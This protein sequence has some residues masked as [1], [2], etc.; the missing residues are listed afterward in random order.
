MLGELDRSQPRVGEQLICALRD[1]IEHGR[2]PQ[3][4]RLP[5]TRDL[6][7]DLGVSRGL[8]VGAY[9]RL[10]A[11]GR[12]AARRG[13]GTVVTAQ[14]EVNA[15]EPGPERPAGH[16]TGIPTRPS[17]EPAVVALRPGVPDLGTF[18]R[19]AWRKAYERALALA[20][21]ADLDYGDPAG[22]FRLRAEL[23]AYLTRIRAARVDVDRLMITSGETQAFALL[24]ETLRVAGVARIGVEDPGS[25][26]VAT[27]LAWHGLEPVAVAVDE[28]GID[29]AA[30]DRAGLTTVVVTPA[31]Q[32]PTGV[33]LMP[34]RRVALLDWARRTGSLIIENDYDAELRYD[35]EPVGCLQG[36][37]PE[38]VM[39]VGSVSTTLAP[40]LRLGWLASPRAW[41]ADLH[42][43]RSLADG[44]GPVLEQL[45]FA[46]LLAG[47]AYDRHLR[48]MRRVLRERR[49]TLVTAL[50]RHLPSARV[51]GAAAGLHLTIE[52]PDGTDDVALATRAQAAGIG[53]LAL[54][55]CLL[56]AGGAAAPADFADPAT[57]NRRTGLVLG[58]AAQSSHELA[59]AVRGLAHLIPG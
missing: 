3:G 10:V 4:T 18:P 41:R 58:Y 32:Y 6:A 21:D 42:R 36:L 24:A 11:E 26:A 23:A 14:S 8:V 46:E 5:S 28:R 9:E 16:G 33:V 47:A 31:H 7:V 39:L 44:G 35:R 12:L 2:L 25:R 20:A 15:A 54:S 50:R 13:R 22:A 19:T 34:D 40:A 30:L 1:A 43:S 53:V 29:V 38:H 45:A 52:L 59:R 55:D 48:R 17:A 51:G 37:A 56:Q 27:R 57:R 49:S